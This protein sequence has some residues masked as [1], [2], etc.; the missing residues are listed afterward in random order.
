MVCVSKYYECIYV[1]HNKSEG[2]IVYKISA[3]VEII[4]G[5]DL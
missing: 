3:P 4:G 5:S 2:T 1:G